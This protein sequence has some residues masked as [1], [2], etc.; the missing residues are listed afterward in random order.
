MVQPKR[1]VKIDGIDAGYA[2][3]LPP[4][5]TSASSDGRDPGA[6]GDDPW[7]RLISGLMDTA[8]KIPGTSIRFGLDP[9]IGLFP[10]I[11][12]SAG[13]IVS[14]GLI[15][16]SARYGI[17]K[18]VLARMAMNALINGVVGTVPFAGDLFSFWFK[19]NAANYELLR[20]HAGTR[21]VST[22]GD[23]I[24]VGGLI[25]GVLLGIGLAVAGVLMVL[26][27]IFRWLF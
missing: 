17:P 5:V 4:H 11:G 7:I 15:A 23:W 21:R 20:K 18:I 25:G 26:N 16:M 27:A 13:A 22:T 1:K 14:V 2:E 19:S 3:V 8:F 9:L 10:G 6:T 12:D 24:F